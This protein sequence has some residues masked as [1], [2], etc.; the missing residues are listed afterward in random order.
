M[1][2]LVDFDNELGTDFTCLTDIDANLTVV[3]GRRGLAESA[4]RRLQTPQ[5][6]LFYDNDYGD[7]LSNLIGAIVVASRI[8]RRSEIEVLKDE[9]V[10]DADSDVT[11]VLP[12]TTGASEDEIGD[13]RIDIRLTDD[14]GPFDLTLVVADGEVTIAN[15]EEFT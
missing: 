1:S 5:F 13:T 4:A 6:G 8:A 10:L 12:E 9:R 3:D 15:L 2:N 11:V 14:D 7:D